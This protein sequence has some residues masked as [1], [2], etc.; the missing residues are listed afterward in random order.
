MPIPP[1]GDLPDPGIKPES[2]ALQTGSLPTE[3]SG[4][5]NRREALTLLGF[6]AASVP[7]WRQRLALSIL[8][9]Q[10]PPPAPRLAPSVNERREQGIT[11]PDDRGTGSQQAP[12]AYD[13]GSGR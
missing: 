13:L 6:W 9:A 8:E 10:R 1:S 5:P 11:C 2:P 4:K 7:G 12:S 3:L